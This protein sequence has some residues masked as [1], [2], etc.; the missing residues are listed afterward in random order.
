M[1]EKL[2]IPKKLKVGFQKRSDTYTKKLAYVIYIDDKGVLRK[3]KSWQSWRDKKIT[4]LDVDNVPHSGF[5]L[6]KDVQRNSEYFGSG[7]N[8]IRVYDDRGIEFE[9]S[10]DNLIF[11]LMNTN[12]HKR[13]LEGEFVYSWFGTELV[14]LPVGC[15]E[16]KK[17]QLFTQVQG[18]SLTKA[19]L[20]PG[21]AYT[22]KKLE[23]LIYLGNFNWREEKYNYSAGNRVT[24][25]IITKKHVFVNENPF[26]DYD[27]DY[28][29]CEDD[30]MS[31]EDFDSPKE[32]QDYLAELEND[33]LDREEWAQ[34]NK[35]RLAEPK[36]LTLTNTNS[37]AVKVSDTPVSN[38][39]ELMQKFSQT[40]HGGVPVAFEE[41]SKSIELKVPRRI[42]DPIKGVFYVKDSEEKYSEYEISPA[43]KDDRNWNAVLIPGKWQLSKQ[44]TFKIQKGRI[45]KERGNS[46][47]KKLTTEEVKKMKFVDLYL[48]LD[49]GEKTTV[50][51]YYS[52]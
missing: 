49:N 30:N 40:K 2:Y 29:D 10:C 14:L 41:A 15:D 50:E 20:I 46:A 7:R 35:D 16:Y 44:N 11:I 32:Y 6:H 33:R 52:Y 18:K 4:P 17:A 38:Y 39:A 21:C 24:T 47:D 19:D 23:T 3:E 8:M 43:T 22:T 37:L 51:K 9:I 26:D 12:C 27:E 36:F 1:E 5:V 25:D 42:T 48:K 45:V 13:G 28:D 31:E 34:E